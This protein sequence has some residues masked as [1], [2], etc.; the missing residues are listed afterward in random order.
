MKKVFITLAVLF[1]AGQTYAQDNPDRLIDRGLLFDIINISGLLLTLYLISN[2]ILRLIQQNLDYRLKQKMVEKSVEEHTAQQL[3]SRNDK[4]FR[5]VMLQWFFVLAGI[6]TG[7]GL[8][9]VIRPFGLHSLAIM[10]LSMAAGFG[11]YYIATKQ[12]KP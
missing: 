9:S 1:L 5:K 12:T 7:F 10:A 2:F 3:L 8:M 4:D 6:G 11:G